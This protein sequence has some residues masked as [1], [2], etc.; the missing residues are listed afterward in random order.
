MIHRRNLTSQY[1]K[2]VDGCGY[3]LLTKKY[4]TNI[5][6]LEVQTLPLFQLLISVS[7]DDLMAVRSTQSPR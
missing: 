3:L 1:L 5:S 7:F 4:K 6:H 2:I